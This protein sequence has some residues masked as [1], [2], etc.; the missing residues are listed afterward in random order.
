MIEISYEEII[1]NFNNDWDFSYLN[2]EEIWEI[3]NHPIKLNDTLSN[4][5]YNKIS[6]NKNSLFL[7]CVKQ[8]KNYDY[9]FLSEFIKTCKEKIPELIVSQFWCNYKYA[10]VKA[11]LGQYAK[12]SLFYHPKF[13]FENHIGIFQIDSKVINLPPRKL[14][15]FNLLPLCNNCND[16]INACPVGAI[17]NNTSTWI[18][19]HACDGFCHFGNHS[20]IPSIKWNWFRV[21]DEMIPLFSS[22]DEIYNI[23]SYIDLKQ[24]SKKINSQ[25]IKIKDKI[26]NVS[27]P[28]CRECTSQKKCS[29]YG[30]SYPYDWNDIKIIENYKE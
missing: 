29:K 11:G 16:C 23:K 7:I 8:T 5:I 20:S 3:L 26:Y 30:G 14:A 19:F 25:Y 22:L 17:H 10:A 28:I 27:F 24:I 6:F 18:D 15:N 21:D 13:Q 4:T 12:N 1:K 2:Y 9:T